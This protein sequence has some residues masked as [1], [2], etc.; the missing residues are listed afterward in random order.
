MLC[1]IAQASPTPL[2]ASRW[3]RPVFV[4]V[5]I[6]NRRK[7]TIFPTGVKTPT[8]LA[9]TGGVGGWLLG[10]DSLVVP[11]NNKINYDAIE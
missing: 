6:E 8:R 9:L 2:Q 10:R 1:A 11:P 4:V 5:S 7:I 3:N